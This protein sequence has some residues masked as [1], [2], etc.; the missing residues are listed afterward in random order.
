MNTVFGSAE[1]IPDENLMYLLHPRM[2]EKLTSEEA[3][4]AL[5]RIN[6]AQENLLSNKN[7]IEQHIRTLHKHKRQEACKYLEDFTSQF[8]EKVSRLEQCS[9][10]CSSKDLNSQKEILKMSMDEI[11][12]ELSVLHKAENYL[13]KEEIDKIENQWKRFLERIE[14]VYNESERRQSVFDEVCEF[15]K[16]LG[17]DFEQKVVNRFEQELSQLSNENLNFYRESV[18]KFINPIVEAARKLSLLQQYQNEINKDEINKMQ[19]SLNN[20]SESVGE[21][22]VAIE[23]EFK[24]RETLSSFEEVCKYIKGLESTWKSE[25][26]RFEQNLKQNLHQFSEDFLK[27]QKENF[28]KFIIRIIDEKIIVA[29]M[30]DGKFLTAKNSKK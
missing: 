29:T 1:Q 19:N 23:N 15:L 12:G 21:I 4:E 9:F 18:L 20:F 11:N 17:T 10:Q 5:K 2:I 14:N 16:R 13:S 28:V 7:K 22:I 6:R 30:P 3:F 25:V 24:R 27:F 26:D 8:G